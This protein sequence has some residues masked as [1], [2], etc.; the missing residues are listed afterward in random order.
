MGESTSAFPSGNRSKE[1]AEML[2]ISILFGLVALAAC[3]NWPN[4]RTTWGL[5]P[6]GAAFAEQPRTESEAASAGWQAIAHCDGK[7]LG[8][9][10]AD[11]SDPSLVMMFASNA[12]TVPV[13]VS[14]RS[15]LAWI[16]PV[17]WV[18]MKRGKPISEG[19]I[20]L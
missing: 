13:Q 20:A 8:H 1:E 2:R 10:Y 9:R 14:A 19:T 11:P 7:F 6:F 3:E 18:S 4:L 15:P 12:G 5:N 16:S 17:A